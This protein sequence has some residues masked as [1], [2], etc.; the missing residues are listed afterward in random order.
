MLIMRI[1]CGYMYMCI[2]DVVV[3]SQLTCTHTHDYGMNGGCVAMYNTDTLTYIA[4]DHN[5]VTTYH[6]SEL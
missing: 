2:C 4:H 6:R 1:S 5:Y 3:E